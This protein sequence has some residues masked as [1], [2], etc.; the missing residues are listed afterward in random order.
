VGTWEVG[1]SI[2]GIVVPFPYPS[3]APLLDYVFIEVD[4]AGRVGTVEV[5]PDAAQQQSVSENQ[6]TVELGAIPVALRWGADG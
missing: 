5:A 3:A 2:G 1:W 6:R 4:S